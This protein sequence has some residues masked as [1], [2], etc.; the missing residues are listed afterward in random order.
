MK[1]EIVHV[2]DHALWRWRERAAERGDAP[3]Y[4]VI[5]AVRESKIVSKGEPLP[6]CLPRLDGSVYSVKDDIVFVMEPVTLGE[7]RLVT[8]IAEPP[9]PEC[10]SME[11]N[12]AN[13]NGCELPENFISA[14]QERDWLVLEKRRLEQILATTPKRTT[15]HLELRKEWGKIEERLVAIKP[16]VQAERQ[17]QYRQYMEQTKQEEGYVDYGQTMLAV[18]RELQ[19]IRQLLEQRNGS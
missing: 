12:M 5:E 10:P 1:A 13:N 11:H 18:L 19:A 14:Q 17:E 4:E 16:R 15:K 3:V 7:Y 2:T 8:V 6:Y 9:K